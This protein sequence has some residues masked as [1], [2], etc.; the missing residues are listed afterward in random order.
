MAYKILL[1]KQF[2]SEN[3]SKLNYEEGRTTILKIIEAIKTGD[4]SALTKEV[5]TDA[6]N[7]LHDLL[8]DYLLNE[9]D[10]S[11]SKDAYLAFTIY[12]VMHS[13]IDELKLMA[14]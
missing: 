8:C 3:A 5:V 2:L 10:A 14:K 9:C 13:F 11:D 4:T 12:R 7:I 6:V 1:V